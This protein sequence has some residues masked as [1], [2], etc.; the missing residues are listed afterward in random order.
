MRNRWPNLAAAFLIIVQLVSRGSNVSAQ[1]G[2]CFDTLASQ[3]KSDENLIYFSRALAETSLDDSLEGPGPYLV[4]APTDIAFSNL[5]GNEQEILNLELSKLVQYHIA[6]AP[7][8]E[9]YLAMT[10]GSTIDI[11]TL[12]SDCNEVTIETLPSGKV[13]VNEGAN[14]YEAVET[15]NGLL[16]II[17]DVLSPSI[18][19]SVSNPSDKEEDIECSV[20]DPT[21]CDLPPPEFSCIQQ[22]IWGKCDEAWMLMGNGNGGFCKYTCG[23]CGR[24]P[25]FDTP[26]SPP[27]YEYDEREGR[28]NDRESENPR[29]RRPRRAPVD[30]R[31][32]CECTED[33]FSGSTD[34][35]QAGCFQVNY[36]E[37]YFADAGG[38]AG[39]RVGETV[40]QYF[41][42]DS[43]QYSNFFGGLWSNFASS[44]A[45]SN[46]QGSA[47]RICYVKDP[48]TCSVSRPSSQFPGA[49][50]RSC[51]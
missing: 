13:L 32:S 44:W 17:N 3:I 35:E 5:A 19:S 33:G 41:G 51:E 18:G 12:C 9:E 38:R 20:D 40:S 2:T 15:C 4:F 43:S 36:A 46:M 14:A 29:S 28:R 16:V 11:R 34:T 37:R 10:P 47:A 8:S 26:S 1:G 27:E 45:R 24:R 25:S 42:G 22:K 48:S 50:W 49:G 30:P 21:C 39:R 6:G 23:R 31:N 7:A